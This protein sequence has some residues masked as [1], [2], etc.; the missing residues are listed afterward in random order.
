MGVHPRPLP[1][2]GG[3]HRAGVPAGR[4]P[5]RRKAD[6]PGAAD[7]GGR[8][9]PLGPVDRLRGAAGAAPG[10]A[11]GAGRRRAGRPPAA[12]VHLRH[13][14]TAQGRADHL[15]EPA[16]QE[17]GADR[18]VRPDRGGHH[19]GGGPALP[20]RRPRHARPAGAVRG[21]RGGAPAQVRRRGRPAGHPGTPG[22]QRLAGA[23]HGQRGPGGPGPGVVRHHLDALHRGRRREDP[24]AGAAADHERLPQRLVRRRLRTDRDGLRR[25]LPRPGARA[26][27]AGLGRPSRG[28][29]PGQDRRRHGQG[30]S[31]SANWARSPCAA[32]RSS[33]ATGAT[34][35]PRPRRSGTAGSTPGTSGTSTRTASSTST[36]ARRT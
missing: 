28:A 20:R 23:R 5:D 21:R 33:R 15:R 4:G 9:G 11:G 36:T 7:P 22:H 24:R 31:G 30:G 17:R 13:H 26:V 1:G 18:A 16:R 8:R 19:A 10:R 32:R 12:D 34:R 2:E 3:R 29:H 25:H 35:R 14:L 27:Q 6:R